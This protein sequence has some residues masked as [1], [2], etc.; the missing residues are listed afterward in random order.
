MHQTQSQCQKHSTTVP[1]A[2]LQTQNLGILRVR[3]TFY[4]GLY[5]PTLLS[6]RRTLPSFRSFKIR[7]ENHSK[8]RQMGQKKSYKRKIH[9]AGL[10][11]FLFVCLCTEYSVQRVMA[12]ENLA[13]WVCLTSLHSLMMDLEIG[14][15]HY[16]VPWAWEEWSTPWSYSKLAAK[17]SGQ[18]IASLLNHQ[19]GEETKFHWHM[20]LKLLSCVRFLAH[21]G[22][23]LWGHREYTETF[24]GNLYQLLLLQAQDFPKIKLW[25][26]R[27][28]HNARP[29]C[30]TTDPNRNQVFS[31]VF[32]DCWWSI[33][34]I[35]QW[36]RKCNH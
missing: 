2:Q 12:P 36:A 14:R 26:Q 18:C 5:M 13:F 3:M 19:H 35:S 31:M 7:Y 17:N 6:S 8:D 30:P 16:K 1:R 29:K 28:Y 15:T 34:P 20:L 21:Q 25:L 27:T 9:Q 33:W 22:L 23:P 32:T 24:E 11:R 10:W 4:P